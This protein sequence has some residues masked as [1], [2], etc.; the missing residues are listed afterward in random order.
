MSYSE[1]SA[2]VSLISILLV[3]L[4]YFSR[5]ASRSLTP[6]P[7]ESQFHALLLCVLLLVAIEVVA[8]IVIARHAPRD[9][10]APKDER[11]RLIVLKAVY[12]SAHVFAVCSLLT[13]S[14][15]HIGANR[16]ALANGVLLSFVLAQIVNYGSRINYYRR[17]V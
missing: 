1:K 14:T 13:I 8:H 10:Q 4:I 16:F 17:G 12:I 3:S 6:A 5:G 9:A 11:E 2:W 15:I 7:S